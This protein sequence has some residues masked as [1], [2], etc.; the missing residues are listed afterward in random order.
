[1]TTSTT[2]PQRTRLLRLSH[3][4]R[5][6]ARQRDLLIGL[7]AAVGVVV[8]VIAAISMDE[9]GFPLD[10]SWIH[11]TYA[12][13]LAEHGE[14][15]FIPG[16]PSVASTSPLYTVLLSIGYVLRIPFMVWT[17]ALGVL[18]LAGGGWIGVRVA[19]RLFPDL[20]TVGLWTGLALVL[21]W[22][23]V[24][25]ASSGM[26][27][28]LFATLSLAVVGLTWRELPERETSDRPVDAFKRGAVLGLVGA[29]LTLTRP[30]GVGLVG[31]A[32]LF[33]LLAWPYGSL[34]DG[35]RTYVAWGAGVSLG[36]LVGVAPYVAVNYNLSGDLLPNTSAAKQAEN[37]PARELPL[38]ERY[39][40]MLLPLSAGGQLLLLP[41]VVMALA[42]LFHRIR[43]G[44]RT[45]VLLLL[46][47][48]WIVMD[49]SAYA[50][51]LP[52]PYQHGR[53]VIPILPHIVLYG[54]GGTL[55]I[56]KA[57]QR[58]PLR[59]VLSRSLAL[60]TLLIMVPFWVIGARAYGRDVRIINTEMVKTAKWIR[61]NPELVPEDELL[62]VHDIG[63]VGY[64]APRPILDLAGLVS[65]E[66]V[67]IIL[68]HEALMGLLRVRCA[69]YLMVLPDQLPAEPD[70]HR[71]GPVEYDAA[72]NK[73]VAQ[74]L[75]ITNEPYAP[76]AGGGNM[77]IYQLRLEWPPECA[78][79]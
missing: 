41:G 23:L 50:I 57:G 43:H 33:V 37:A 34:R 65:P 22:H 61:D 58:T 49:V 8:Y 10:D 26:E 39:G 75:F 15:A 51:R 38:L 55:L 6:A 3:L 46:P 1:M 78:E 77:A 5:I 76:D 42:R 14:W 72:Q 70:D 19:E 59:R 73:N 7:V 18:A 9:A 69:R 48:A 64:Y 53:Y 60:S 20:R 74:P 32:G 56:V 71:L 30:E 52:A 62:A 68:D 47:L 66:V 45:A 67:P 31:L 27:T 4:H 16:E 63:A 36:W 12:R 25:A 28:M 35:W 21:V 13:N 2:S 40:R 44:E 11:Q 24:W 79:K 17:F 29:L 54:V